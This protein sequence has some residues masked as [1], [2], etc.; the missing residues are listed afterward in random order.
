MTKFTYK[1]SSRT[2]YSPGEEIFQLIDLRVILKD[3]FG[4]RPGA[5]LHHEGAN[6]PKKEKENS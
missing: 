6:G 3:V 2:S 5:K 1:Q 4:W